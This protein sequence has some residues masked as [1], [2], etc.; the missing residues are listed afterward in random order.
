MG[1]RLGALT[2]DKPKALVRVDDRELILRVMDFLDAG[3]FDERIVVTGYQ[4]DALTNFLKEHRPDVTIL[5]NPDFELGSIKTL[6][7]ALSHLDDDFLLMNAD[8]IYPK[9]MLATILAKREGIMAI[10]DFDRSLCADD[11]KIR[12]SE[13]NRITAI[14]KQLD[15]CDGG[16]IG[17]TWCS[18]NMLETY[19]TAIERTLDQKSASANV[20]A[21]LDLLSSEDERVGICDVSG[22][23]WLEIDTQDDLNHATNVLRNDP[24]FLS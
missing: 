11:M 24:D 4:S 9:R 19:R 22:H 1:N 6:Q 23:K 3:D 10:C 12:R 5:Y 13:D 18:R 15:R 21:V 20:E 8:H 2:S 7:V 17:M 16:Y 14:S